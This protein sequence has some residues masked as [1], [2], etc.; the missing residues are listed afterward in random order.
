[1]V[2]VVNS[3]KFGRLRW[4]IEESINRFRSSGSGGNSGDRLLLL[5]GLLGNINRSSGG[6]KGGNSW[7]NHFH[8]H[9]EWLSQSLGLVRYWSRI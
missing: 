3:S 8:L 7:A 5:L 9:R 6:S 4:R 1:L 2:K